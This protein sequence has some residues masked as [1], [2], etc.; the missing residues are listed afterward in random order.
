MDDREAIRITRDNFVAQRQKLDVMIAML[1]EQLGEQPPSGPGGGLPTDLVG[2]GV[3]GGAAGGDPVA[4]TNEGAYFGFTSTKAAGEILRL[5]GDQHHPLKTK[6]IF[7]AL[8]K[9]GV[10]IASEDGLY[11]S[12]SR[13]RNFRKVGKALWGLSEWYP[14]PPKRAGSTP[15]NVSSLSPN[16]GAAVVDDEVSDEESTEVESA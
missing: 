1:S 8:K 13:S 11:R 5:Y 10:Q 12:L 3:G 9:G 16:G 15:D 14:T 7:D 4:G 6:Q 2:A